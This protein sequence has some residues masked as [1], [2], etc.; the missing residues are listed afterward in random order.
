MVG[1]VWALFAGAGW[2]F[3]KQVSVYTGALF[4]CCIV[5]HGE[6]FRIRPA[7][8]DLTE[9]YLLIATGGALGGLFASLAAP[10]LFINYYELH[11]GLALCG[12][13]VIAVR[14]YEHAATVLAGPR[15]QAGDP[16]K[17]KPLNSAHGAD[18]WKGLEMASLWLWF[19]ALAVAL[20]IQSR[21]SNSEIVYN[22]RNF[23]GVLTVFEHRK[24]EPTGHHFLLQH[25]RITHGFQ[26]VHPQLQSLPT[27]YYGPDSGLGLALAA[28]PLGNRRIGVVGLGTGTIAAYGRP[29]DFFEFYEINP[30]VSCL[31]TSIFTYLAG[32]KA[33]CEITAGDARLALERQIPQQF[34]LVALDAF[35][36]DS[37]PVHLLTRE[38]FKTYLRHLKPNGV[39]AVHTS[40]H[41][42]NLEPV[43]AGLAR[44]FG[45]Q[46]A[47][48][49]HDAKPE[50]W[51]IYSSTWVLL[52]RDPRPFEVET[53]RS[54]TKN[55]PA[56]PS[57]LPLWTDDYSSL[58]Q[59]L[60]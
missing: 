21:H 26:F 12:F 28:L 43:V 14:T 52:S 17:S 59:I 39:L 24:D 53:I 42:L 1:F 54:A 23:Y 16:A 2:A 30:Q 25:G 46:S 11:W 4:V 9:F 48:V 58:F 55:L 7:P 60:R 5:C 10:R 32:C 18:T 41:F 19:F 40:N 8:R 31:A 47:V 20:W 29:G 56:S 33:R 15:S 3:W 57:P 37:I 49:D 38:A 44:E 13:L 27:T 36:S 6:L 34:D 51:W 50:Q 22:S 35:N 45:L